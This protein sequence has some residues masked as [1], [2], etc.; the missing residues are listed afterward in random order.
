MNSISLT[1]ELLGIDVSHNNGNI[2]WNKVKSSHPRIRFAYIKATQGVGYTDPQAKNFGA[3]ALQS[4]LRIGYYHFA[5]LNSL[6]IVKDAQAEADYFDAVLKTLSP[7]TLPPV[8]D[9]ETNEKRLNTQQ[10]EEWITNFFQ[11]MQAHGHLRVFIYSYKPFFDSNLPANHQFGNM[12]LW[13]AQY[14]NVPAPSLPHG[15]NKFTI[16]QYTDKGKVDGIS[17]NCD[18]N[19][20]HA[21]IFLPQQ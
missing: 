11:R 16:W 15:W 19:K 14:R 10:V 6:D 21:E 17:G 7:A 8:L 20:A 18:M 12:P 2:N 9:I 3:G 5:S 13:L 1:E 4:G